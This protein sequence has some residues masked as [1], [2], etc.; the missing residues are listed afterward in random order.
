MGRIV[1]VT[2]GGYDLRALAASLDAAIQALGSL[3]AD[4]AWPSSPLSSTRGR[5]AVAAAKQSLK[6]FW[7]L[8]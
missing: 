6:P 8:Q 5:N 2:E 1:L 7:K 4:P 3:S